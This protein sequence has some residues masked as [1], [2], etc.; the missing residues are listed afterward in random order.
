MRN[1]DLGEHFDTVGP[2]S[3]M[4]LLI[5]NPSEH[6]HHSCLPSRYAPPRSA[7]AGITTVNR[8]RTKQQALQ[9]SKG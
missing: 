6:V 5:T 9:F 3:A 7:T 2:N 8:L 1:L 4:Q